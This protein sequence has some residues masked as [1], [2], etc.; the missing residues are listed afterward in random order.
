MAD[1][2]KGK[3]FDSGKPMMDLVPV[4]FMIGTAQAL[5]FGV[6][7]YGAHNYREGLF[8]AKLLAAAY[9]HLCLELA[10]ARVDQETGLEHWKLAAAELSMYAFMKAHRPAF[11]NLYQYT[12]EEIARIEEMMYGP[13]KTVS[14]AP[15]GSQPAGE[16]FS[17]G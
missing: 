3:K 14:P 16:G 4:E 2:N 12:P 8:Y 11:N 1:N 9:R 10:G 17:H 15:T 5:T 7:K 13:M 6:S